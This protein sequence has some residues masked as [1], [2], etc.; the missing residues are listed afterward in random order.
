MAEKLTLKRIK[1]LTFEEVSPKGIL[2]DSEIVGFGVRVY[3]SGKKAFV[4]SYRQKGKK[5]LY[6]IG[7]CGRVTLE[8]ARDLAKKRFGEVADRKDPVLE[9]KAE[10]KK[11][12]HTV[13]KTVKKFIE[14]YAKEHTRNWQ[15]AERILEKDVVPVIGRKAVEEVTKDDIISILDNV[16]ERKAKIMA[17]R[18]LAHTRRFFNWCVERNIIPYSPAFKIAAPSKNT[19]RDRVLDD[20]EIKEIWEA[21]AQI[22][23]PFSS[24]LKFLVLTGQRRGEAASMQW[25]D[26][27]EKKKLWIIPRES[28]KSDREHIVPLSDMAL[29]IIQEMPKLGLYVFSDTGKRPF[30]NFSRD[31]AILDRIIDDKRKKNKERTIRAW[32]IHD[33]RR[34][35]ASGMAKL[36]IAPHV[37]EKLLNH[38][39]GVI[40]GVAAVYNR[41]QYQDEMRQAI[42]LWA[43]HVE[44]VLADET[45][46]KS[47]IGRS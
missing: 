8:Q 37:V 27:D 7:Q 32:R 9:R 38:S 3:P 30:E 20:H 25:M 42:D 26:I 36:G 23:D 33:V 40:S 35:L 17:N 22:A 21:T 43:D 28:N 12:S 14:Q 29:S 31:K 5:R 11:S 39:T 10:K 41:Y 18:T 2:W 47:Y 34:T 13:E 45:V 24:L 19:S 1:D 15:E 6:T 46:E 16:I 44:S 4:L